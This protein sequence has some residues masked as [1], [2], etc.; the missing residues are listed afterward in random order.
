M[1]ASPSSRKLQHLTKIANPASRGSLDD[2]KLE[3]RKLNKHLGRVVL[4][5]APTKSDDI[6]KL[7]ESASTRPSVGVNVD[8]PHSHHDDLLHRADGYGSVTTLIHPP[9]KGTTPDSAHMLSQYYSH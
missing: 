8:A 7:L 6:F 9:V 4:D 2:M 5:Q 3:I 1:S